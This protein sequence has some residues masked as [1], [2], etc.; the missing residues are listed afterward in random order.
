MTVSDYD[1]RRDDNEELTE[2]LSNLHSVRK[3]FVNC[4]FKGIKENNFNNC[5]FTCCTFD[6]VSTSSFSNC[7]FDHC[8]FYMRFEGKMSNCKILNHN[9]LLI[10]HT[11][12]R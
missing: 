11:E 4:S 10:E 12:M 8:K 5:N 7:T 2:L 6:D 3:E 1:Y 9:G